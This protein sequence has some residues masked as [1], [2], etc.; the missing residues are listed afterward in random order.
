MPQ[1]SC[2]QDEPPARIPDP[3]ILKGPQFSVLSYIMSKDKLLSELNQTLS[4]VYAQYEWPVEGKD[5]VILLIPNFPKNVD[6]Q[7]QKCKAWPKEVETALTT[8]LKNFKCIDIPVEEGIWLQVISQKDGWATS[9]VDVVEDLDSSQLFIS[10]RTDSVEQVEDRVK[11]VIKDIEEQMQKAKQMIKDNAKLNGA[12]VKQLLMCSFARTVMQKFPDVDVKVTSKN[13]QV[14]FEGLPNDVTSAKCEMY[15]TLNNMPKLRIKPKTQSQLHFLQQASASQKIYDMFKERKVQAVYF[16]ENDEVVLSAMKEDVLKQACEILKRSIIEKKI[17]LKPR[18]LAAIQKQEWSLLVQTLQDEHTLTVAI[19]RHNQHAVFVTGLET[20]VKSVIPQLQNYI[21]LNSDESVKIE[22]GRMLYLQ[23]YTKD[24]ISNI[25]QGAKRLPLRMNIQS[26]GQFVILT[27]SGTE[28]DVKIAA[29]ELKQL[30][31]SVCR[32]PYPVDKP[33]MAKLF[34]GDKGKSYLNMTEVKFKCIIVVNNPSEEDSTMADSSHEEDFEEINVP[35]AQPTTY[36]ILGYHTLKDGRRI[37]VGKGDLTK[38]H[39]DVIVNAANTSLDSSTGGLTKAVVDAG[40]PS[41][42]AECA[43]IIKTRGGTLFEGQA[44]S[45]GPGNLPCKCI[46]HAVGPVWHGSGYGHWSGQYDDRRKEELLL[47]DAV[48]N[49][50]T[51]AEQ[52]GFTSIAI[53]AIS[54]GGYGFPLDLCVKTIMM[55]VHHYCKSSQ[56]KSL[57]EIR[58][59]DN[60]DATCQKFQ[61]ALVEQYGSGSVVITGDEKSTGQWQTLLKVIDHF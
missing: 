40:G 1:R 3:I 37:V 52:M 8:F 28:D 61:D 11:R 42:K 55:T 44:V 48:R 29:K 46:I 33:G 24:E 20:S 59:V 41:I 21:S 9:D 27:I 23:T 16:I 22:N 30:A 7:F 5:N 50:L 32:R 6:N 14:T 57:M 4:K 26:K 35:K 51:L 13:N 56:P 17:V 53:P 2:E 15:E 49:S 45:T 38:M 19:P 60:A 34:T 47:I 54:A 18:S 39:V 25:Q 31:D 58:I 12:K 36:H 10:G 43:K